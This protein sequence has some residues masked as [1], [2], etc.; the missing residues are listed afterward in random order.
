MQCQ[1]KSQTNKEFKI[2]EVSFMNRI[3]EMGFLHVSV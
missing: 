3:F 1:Y 2:Q